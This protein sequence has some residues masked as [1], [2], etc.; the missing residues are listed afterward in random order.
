M[1]GGGASVIGI[2]GVAAAIICGLCIAIDG[3]AI[4]CG[5]IDDTFAAGCCWFPAFFG[6][7]DVVLELPPH[8]RGE[9]GGEE[10]EH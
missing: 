1:G 8:T 7:V 4:I 6:V 10:G 5:A 3:V 9:G 2:G